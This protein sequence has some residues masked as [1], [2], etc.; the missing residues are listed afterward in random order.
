MSADIELLRLAAKAAGIDV[1]PNEF[2]DP[3]DRKYTCDLG[4]WVRTGFQDI[5]RWFN[6]LNDDG[7]ALRLAVKLGLEIKVDLCDDTTR[8]NECDC[9]FLVEHKH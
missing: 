2:C 7:E 1:G 9:E 3:L 6:P 4:L 8:V 5:G